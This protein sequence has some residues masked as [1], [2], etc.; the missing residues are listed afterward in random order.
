MN[1][2]AKNTPECHKNKAIVLYDPSVSENYEYLTYKELYEISS[3]I[4]EFISKNIKERCTCIGL[5]FSHNIYLPCVVL[6]YVNLVFEVFFCN[7][8][9]SLRKLQHA[10][11]FL[12]SNENDCVKI[13]KELG[14]GWIISFNIEK[15]N[16]VDFII[17]KGENLLYLTKTGYH[18]IESYSNIFYVIQTSG[19]TGENKLVQVTHQCIESNIVSLRFDFFNFFC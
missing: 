15:E 10:F 14:I 4:S 9:I 11:I 17:L 12:S 13:I 16:N 8:N 3:C 18:T 1:Y 19:T 7:V 6:R 5:K 2:L